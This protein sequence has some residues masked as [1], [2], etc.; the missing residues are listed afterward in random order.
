MWNGSPIIFSL[1]CDQLSSGRLLRDNPYLGHHAHTN[2]VKPAT[3]DVVVRTTFMN[4][5]FINEL[6]KIG[7]QLIKIT[8]G[9]IF[10]HELVILLEPKVQSTGMLKSD[11][12]EDP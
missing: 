2:Y 12:P 10:C 4:Q 5:H 7:L 8:A 9:R 11:L 1:V 3:C 6:D